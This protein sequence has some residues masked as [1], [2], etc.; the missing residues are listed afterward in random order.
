MTRCVRISFLNL[1]E[2]SW[3]FVKLLGMLLL[4]AVNESRRQASGGAATSGWKGDDLP[5]VLALDV[6]HVDCCSVIIVVVQGY[7]EKGK[8]GGRGGIP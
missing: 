4:A 6:H 3:L 5:A 2:K 8:N 1:W 7:I